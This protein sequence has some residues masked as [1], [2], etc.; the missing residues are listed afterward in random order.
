MSAKKGCFKEYWE[1]QMKLSVREQ[2]GSANVYGNNPQS[3][4]NKATG[5]HT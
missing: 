4:L 1:A 3:I 5:L 2:F